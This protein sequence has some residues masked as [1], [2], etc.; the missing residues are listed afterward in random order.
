MAQGWKVVHK[1]NVTVDNRLDNLELVK[2]D[3]KQLQ[4]LPR[5][6]ESVVTGSGTSGVSGDSGA[7]SDSGASGHNRR[8][9]SSRENSLYWITITQLLGDSLDNVR[10]FTVMSTLLIL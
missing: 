10:C 2:D 7:S 3:G 9:K 8:G 1:N 5:D 4:P 6:D